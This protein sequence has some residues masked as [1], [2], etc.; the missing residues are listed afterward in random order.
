MKKKILSILL[1]VCMVMCLFSVAT[2][3]GAAVSVS[4]M[5]ES[6]A[7]QNADATQITT[8]T[9]S[10]TGW[11]YV[12]G[13][14]TLDKKVTLSGNMNL[15]LNDG[16]T[17]T[18]TGGIDAGNYTLTVYGQS[19][20]S[21]NLIVTSS[22]NT[23]GFNGKL[24]ANGANISITGGL[25]TQGTAGGNNSAG[26]DDAGMG[27]N[28]LSG[29]VT[30]NK[31]N[32]T[33]TG[34]Q[35][36]KGG[37]GGPGQGKSKPGG[38]GGKGGT[39]GYAVSATSSGSVAVNNGTL[40]LCGGAAG[41]GGDGGPGSTNGNGAQGETGAEGTAGKAV[42]STTG[43]PS[44]A[45]VKSIE[46]GTTGYST[47]NNS[48]ELT[49]YQNIRITAQ[50]AEPVEIPTAEQNLVYNASEQTGV[51]FETTDGFTVSNNK[52]TNAGTY[53]ATATL[54]SGYI[55][56]DGSSTDK[57]VQF[58]IAKKAITVTADDVTILQGETPTLTYK[59]NISLLGTDTFTGAL[60]VDNATT[61]LTDMVV[62]DYDIL[63]GTLTVS[64]GNSGNNYDITY[65][66]G[67]L[68][69]ESKWTD[70]NIDP[71]ETG[72]DYGIEN[73]ALKD[74][75]F[76]DLAVWAQKYDIDY[77]DIV[78]DD[79]DT[80]VDAFLLNCAPED[81]ADEAKAYLDSVKVVHND[82]GS[83]T[84]EAVTENTDGSAFNG[85][86]VV[87]DN[88]EEKGIGLQFG[89]DTGATDIKTETHTLTAWHAIT[90]S[91]QTG[92]LFGRQ[93]KSDNN[94]VGRAIIGLTEE[95]FNLI[96]DYVTIV[97]NADGVDTVL[98]VECA[99][100]YFYNNGNKVSAGDVR[101]SKGEKMFAFIII[102]DTVMQRVDDFSG[103]G[104]FRLYNGDVDEANYMFDLI[105]MPK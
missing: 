95:E 46:V 12:D 10:F 14:V 71:T 91:V 24:S 33:I 26:L 3:S 90:K 100:T 53:N 1:T 54:K 50:N 81:A 92:G 27:A 18:V 64:D 17:L 25:G 56:S 9:T 22:Q 42:Q 82:D 98:S 44:A 43:L 84:L 96:D 28:G 16:A 89:T 8:S 70:E 80:Y 61:A 103:Y 45:S 57:T 94:K 76:K 11:L 34:G 97:G 83:W 99:Y 48:T 60:A 15:I 39:G 4:Y 37:T 85:E 63:Q 38:K 59:T 67:T 6:G 66:K 86:S 79:S 36:G 62:Y 101:N 31:G 65:V 73:N 58:T 55:W 93:V 49:T 35:G 2:I 72:A 69:V 41:V 23:V 29:T 74:A 105:Y 20:Q 32:V 19:A 78:A 75:N 87:F 13:S 40:T 77:A 68:T 21:G 102:D 30:V 52:A 104:Y 88:D 47:W 51:V 7:S 5:T